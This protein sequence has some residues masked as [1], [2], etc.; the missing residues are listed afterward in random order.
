[1]AFHIAIAHSF[2]T[3][4]PANALLRGYDRSMMRSPL[5][6]LCAFIATAAGCAATGAPHTTG[7]GTDMTNP[8]HPP[9]NAMC[10][11][12]LKRDLLGATANAP[13]SV[14]HTRINSSVA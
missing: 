6:L 8:S 5:L 12:Q 2:S 3:Y 13:A 9:L 10:T 14:L 7:A 1:M 4:G 11:V